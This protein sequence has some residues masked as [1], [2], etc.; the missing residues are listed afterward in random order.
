MGDRH[1]FFEEIK[2][3]KKLKMP[4]VMGF[5]G[6]FHFMYQKYYK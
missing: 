6:I 4:I 1:C 2:I 3:E 5:I